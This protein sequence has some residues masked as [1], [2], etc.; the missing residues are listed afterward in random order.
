MKKVFLILI[1]ILSVLW[2]KAQMGGPIPNYL[3]A[4]N[5]NF[6]VLVATQYNSGMSY[7]ELGGNEFI[8]LNS[9]NFSSADE[10]TFIDLSNYIW[11]KLGELGLQPA[12]FISL[13]YDKIASTDLSKVTE[14]AENH[15]T[16]FTMTILITDR[17]S[18]D[19]AIKKNNKDL[20]SSKMVTITVSTTD[21]NMD[22]TKTYM[23]YGAGLTLGQAF[24][25]IASDI[26]KQKPDYFISKMDI[27]EDIPDYSKEDYDKMITANDSV[28]SF[29]AE[30]E[31]KKSE[32]LVLCGFKKEST[33]YKRFND[34]MQKK[35]PYK[36]RIITSQEYWTEC[37]KEEYQFALLLKGNSFAYTA[38][39]LD[40]LERNVRRN[41]MA[42]GQL[43]PRSEILQ[44]KNTI[45]LTR[46]EQTN[47]LMNRNLENSNFNLFQYV[48][49]DLKSLTLYYGPCKECENSSITSALRYNLKMMGQFYKWSK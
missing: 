44:K 15:N 27:K 12:D 26:K 6:I 21:N 2:T 7:V 33:S 34:L 25:K 20:S 38:E 48:I 47:E 35:Y 10:K 31:L 37:T 9:E 29:P 49:K 5:S 17:S 11:N 13:N 4:S 16:G 24:E 14:S 18:I 40:F 19:K 42:Q 46:T 32:L 39:G 28:Y 36:Y 45:G 1:T 30:E 23:I 8:E 22:V 41:A 3:L 43:R